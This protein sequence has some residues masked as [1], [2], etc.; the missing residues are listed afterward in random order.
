MVNSDTPSAKDLL[1]ISSFME[2]IYSINAINEFKKSKQNIYLNV[3]ELKLHSG[4]RAIFKNFNLNIKYDK[5]KCKAF[6]RRVI[7]SFFIERMSHL[8]SN[9]SSSLY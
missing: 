5:I 9:F 4:S 2:D 7:F 3:I 1:G 8:Q 6:E